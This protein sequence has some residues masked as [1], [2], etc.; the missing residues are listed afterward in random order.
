MQR[1]GQESAPHLRGHAGMAPT[2]R[3]LCV[4][5][6]KDELTDDFTLQG[7]NTKVQDT[8]GFEK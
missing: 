1:P 2:S 7:P 8:L 6:H 4:Y 5:S 3:E